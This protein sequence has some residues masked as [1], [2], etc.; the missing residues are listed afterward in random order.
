MPSEETT[1][2]KTRKEMLKEKLLANI[3]V[4]RE[5]IP[6]YPEPTDEQI[7]EWLSDKRI[8]QHDDAAAL[9][10]K[11]KEMSEYTNRFDE[12]PYA[13]RRIGGLLLD[14]SGTPEAEAYNKKVCTLLPATT[15]EGQEFRKE[16]MAKVL[17]SIESTEQL[18]EATFDEKL[19]Y[20]MAHFQKAKLG[21]DIG[22]TV[23][24][25]AE[26]GFD[27]SKEEKEALNAYGQVAGIPAATSV[28]VVAS[29]YFLTMPPLVG[30]DITKTFPLI[31]NA[32]KLK[33]EHDQSPEQEIGI[34]GTA[35][36]LVTQF[37]QDSFKAGERQEKIV[38]NPHNYTKDSFE[39]DPEKTKKFFRDFAQIKDYPTWLSGE[40]G[41]T[42]TELYTN[43]KNADAWYNLNN[44]KEYKEM[45]TALKQAGE[46]FSTLQGKGKLDEREKE[47][48]DRLLTEIAD[49]AEKYELHVGAKPKNAR[50]ADRLGIV[51]EALK[52]ANVALPKEKPVVQ[53]K[54]A[55]QNEKTVSS[56]QAAN[57]AKE[58]APKQA[59]AEPSTL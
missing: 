21:F 37:V 10:K 42:F 30:M 36:D 23:K 39:V 44:S 4:V 13:F 12:K 51:Q 18:S 34:K 48:A 20:G 47:V 22:Y 40:K 55:K 46:F 24:N 58:Q 7:D 31:T 3:K 9:E 26:M 27:I 25:I 43:L 32:K 35:T 41:R 53:E 57:A 56:V 38:M 59:E 8:K 6:D 50:Q 19:E 2:K 11:N 5:L 33:S 52:Q 49:K 17:N 14:W 1:T 28:R 29:D 54:K 16:M 45:L 15:N